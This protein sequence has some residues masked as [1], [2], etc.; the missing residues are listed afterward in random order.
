MFT[1]LTKNPEV[2]RGTLDLKPFL[3][4]MHA[5]LGD[6]PGLTDRKE[7]P[8]PFE[9]L[10][11]DP[12]EII[13]AAVDNSVFIDGIQSAKIISYQ[14][15][16]PVILSFTSAGGISQSLKPVDLVETL[17][18]VC[19]ESNAEDILANGCPVA[20]TTVADNEN[21]G[22]VDSAVR[23]EINKS[24][25]KQEFLLAA[26]LLRADNEGLVI[27]DGHLAH[28]P[29]D[30]RM[31]GIVKTTNTNLIGDESD[32]W[33]LREGWRSPLFR[34]PAD[35]GG[36]TADRYSAYVRLRSSRNRQ[37]SHGLIRVETYDPE[38]IDVAAGIA[39][40]NRQG[41]R[42]TDPR[43]DRHVTPVAR[44]EKWLKSRI[45]YYLAGG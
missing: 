28:R 8:E 15:H 10:E 40:A 44:V 1:P 27:A 6:I 9:M 32:L 41:V 3:R 24:R 35:F 19:C 11:A 43:G 16:R 4:G 38:M 12:V 18:V 45:P 36:G 20:V 31:L 30:K 17:E 14:D 26:R 2:G 22:V 13:P 33:R 37:W 25:D 23:G 39:L 7:V 42:T 21:P 29:E 34:V 5:S